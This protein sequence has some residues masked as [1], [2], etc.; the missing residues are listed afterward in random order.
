MPDRLLVVGPAWVGDM[1]MS[2]SLLMTLAAQHPETTID[3]LAPAWSAPL[4][5]RMP[6]VQDTIEMPLGHGELHFRLRRRLGR[7]LVDRGY[8][9]AI[10]LPRSL[11][12]ALVPFFAGATKRTGYLGEMRYGLLND[13]RPLDKTRLSK[14]VQR[15][16]ALGLAGDA[17]Q[18]PP[19]PEPRL[20]IDSA[21]QQRQLDAL[22]L[23]T[24]TPIVALMPGAEYGPAKCWPLPYYGQVAAALAAE[25]HQVWIL[26]SRQEVAA[27]DSIV[28]ESGGVAKNLCGRTRL[29]DAVDLLALASVAVTNDSG[30]MHVAAAVGCHVIAIYGSSTP[31]YTPP[32]T[33]RKTVL[34][35]HLECSPCFERTCPLG[36]LRCLR[37]IGPEQVLDA[38][39][40]RRMGP[41]PNTGSV[42]P[43]PARRS[44]DEAVRV[45]GHGAVLY[46]PALDCEWTQSS[47]EPAY[48]L[49]EGAVLDK[50]E[51][52]RGAVLFVRAGDHEWALRHYRRGGLVARISRDRY[53]WTGRER[54]RGFREWRILRHLYEL[55]LPV[56]APVAAAYW[57]RGPFYT[58]DLIT[59]RIPGALALSTRLMSASLDERGWHALGMCIRR[60]HDAGLC[61]ADLNAGNLLLD[62]D[63]RP[64]LIDFDRGR[65]RSAGPWR[66]RNLDR[67]RRSL[68]TIAVDRPGLHFAAADWTALI[69]GYDQIP[70]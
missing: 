5:R 15:Y 4:L 16:V 42:R 23:D 35:R 32:L 61:H 54:T 22:G 66:Q 50:S 11:K 30:L 10:V 53:V 65:I 64:W 48:W 47:F 37:E 56:P 63:D 28:W 3:V 59:R 19:I 34:F 31:D 25:G 26:G 8:R 1:V 29:V 24:D 69:G 45:V 13:I 39:A 60:F 33:E 27:G 21:N 2:Q 49:A 67:L 43:R 36:H 9:Q 68:H 58:A 57:R 51:A 12:S 20:D 7:S 40:T 38:V 14:T 18:P 62:Q 44:V 17:A 41:Q 55:G 70:A 46:D 52:G 6:Q